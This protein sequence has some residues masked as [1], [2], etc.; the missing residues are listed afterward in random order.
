MVQDPCVHIQVQCCSRQISGYGCL[1]LPRAW[2]QSYDVVQSTFSEADFCHVDLTALNIKQL[3]L[4]VF[5]HFE[6]LSITKSQTMCQ[7]VYQASGCALAHVSCRCKPPFLARHSKCKVH[8]HVGKHTCGLGFWCWWMM[9]CRHAPIS[10][11]MVVVTLPPLSLPWHHHHHCCRAINL[12]ANAH[13]WPLFGF[14]MKAK[15][16]LHQTNAVY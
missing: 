13:N 12:R 1:E 4:S 5:Q 11:V 15:L 2:L 7:N 6:A 14:T 8:A 16:T 10:A 9:C 3:H